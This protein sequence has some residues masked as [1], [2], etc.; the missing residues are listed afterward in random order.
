MKV[1]EI[2]LLSTLYAQSHRHYHDINHVN[3]CLGKLEEFKDNTSSS[4]C[5]QLTY[6]IV[7][8]AIWW[9]DAVYNPFSSKNEENSSLLF[10]DYFNNVEETTLYEFNEVNAAILAT[11]HHIKDQSNIS[12][13]TQILLD[14]DLVGLASSWSRFMKNSKAIRKEFSHIDTDTFVKNHRAFFN[15]LL[16]RK[17]I[18]YTDYFHEKYE[19]IARDNINDGRCDI[20]LIL[21][22]S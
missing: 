16:N 3:Y 7:E 11:E 10:S 2:A 13:E 5:P 15:T 19:K 21:D 8:R 1:K 4:E 17:R 6:D 22:R 12:Y 18:Y 14:I 9:H 20:N